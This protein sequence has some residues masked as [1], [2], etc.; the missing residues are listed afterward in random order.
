[1]E[2][3]RRNRDCTFVIY[4]NATLVDQKFCEDM[5]EC[6]NISLALSLEGSEESNDW[7]RG[8]GA[9][10]HTLAAMELLQ[11]NKCLFGISVCY[12]R[13]NV[14]QVTSDEFIDMVLEKG[15]KYALYF[16]Y[17]P[18]GH[19]ADPALIPTPAQRE[20]MYGWMKRI[21]NSKTGKPLFVMDF[22][23]DGEY[24]AGASRRAQLFPHQFRRRHRAVRVH[25][26]F[27]CEHPHAH[28][29][30]GAQVP[31]FMEYYHNQPF[32][33][34]HLRPCPLP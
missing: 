25:P 27:R 20:Y 5:N 2:L 1:M 3:A 10:K 26:L 12:T 21:R 13:K 34:N 8:D 16:N 23:D 17:M 9:Y 6:G 24:V 22:Q 30:R 11:K 31:L 32:N 14:D 18:V 29:Q 15:V 28:A 7:R 4:T 33:D 19:D